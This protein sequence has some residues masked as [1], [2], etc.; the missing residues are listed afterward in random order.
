MDQES[1]FVGHSEQHG[2][3]KAVRNLNGINIGP[4]TPTSRNVWTTS[5]DLI[6][7]SADRGFVGS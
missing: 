1:Q 4:L 3:L 5:A 2:E 6:R 7:R